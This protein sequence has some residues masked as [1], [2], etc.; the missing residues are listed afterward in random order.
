MYL[1]EHLLLRLSRSNYADKFILKGGML[2]AAITGMARRTT[3]DMDATVTGIDM[4]EES[5][6][7]AVRDICAVRIDDG[8]EY[9]LKRIAPIHDEGEYANWRAHIRVR[10]GRID[11]PLKL[12]ITTG[13]AITPRQVEFNYPLMLDGGTVGVLSYPLVTILAEKLETVVRRGSGNTRGRD[14]YDIFTFMRTKR[15]SIDVDLLKQALDATASKRG[16]TNLMADYAAR[17][18]EVRASDAMARVWER[19][20]KD[21][22]YA[23][24]IEFNEVVDAA[25][26][27][28]NM[29]MK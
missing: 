10:Y 29:A 1:F 5:V 2:I 6:R 13:D 4:D 15:D 27:L 12:D 24:G 18:E 3:M 16:S 25:L 9:E 23:R 26:E 19:Y 7:E 8:M 20:V 17:I 22:P 21:T 14:F 11:A 28:G